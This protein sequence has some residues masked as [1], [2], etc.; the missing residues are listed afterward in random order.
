V[1]KYGAYMCNVK[2][3]T[4]IAILSFS[5]LTANPYNDA[6]SVNTVSLSQTE[7]EFTLPEFEI[8]EYVAQNMTFAKIEMEGAFA[9]AEAGLP[10]LPHFSATI[11]VPIGS[12]PVF[13]EVTFSTPRYQETLPIIPVQNY[14][15]LPINEQESP[16]L[17]LESMHEAP[18]FPQGKGDYFDYNTSFYQ[19]KDI[20]I[21]YPQTFYF[22]T[23]VQTLRDYQFIIIK[24]Y[25]IKYTPANNSIEIIDSF[26]FTINHHTDITPITY[27]A[28]PTISK[29]FEKIYEHTFQ[30]YHQVR[31]PNPAYQEQSIL[32]IYGG[33]S[34]V[35]TP[36]FWG[37][38][39]NMVNLKKQKGFEV[40]VASTQTIGATT[41]EIKSYIQNLY[42]SSPNPPEWIILLGITGAYLLP[43]YSV[44]FIGYPG[45]SDYPYTHLAGNDYIGDA[46]IGRIPPTDENQLNNFWQKI[47][48]YEL[49]TPPT[50]PSLYK[51]ALL[52]GHSQNSGI[53]T[54]IVNRYIKSLIEDYDPTANIQEMYYNNSQSTN[55]HNN[56]NAGHNIFNFR[57]YSGMDYFSVNSITNTN[58]LTNVLTL[59]CQT[60]AYLNGT[61]VQLV[62]RSYNGSPAGAISAIGIHT[63]HTETEYNNV[64]DGGIFYAMYVMDVAT[65][66][67]ALLYGKIFT[68]IVYPDNGQTNA[69]IHWTNLMGDPS[70]YYFKTTPSIFATTLPTTITAGTQSFRFVITD[71]AGNSV[72]DAWVTISKADGS[73]V[74]KA[75]SDSDGV[76]I[77]P[78]DHQQ[79]GSLM[80]A[81]SKPGFHVKR[82]SATITGNA[83]ITVIDKVINDPAPGGNDSQTINPGEAIYLGIKV[84]NFTSSDATDLTATISTESE[85][86]TLTGDTMVTLGS[87]AA[88]TEAL[89]TDAFSFEVSPLVPDKDLLPFAFVITDGELSWTSY[90]LLEVQGID[91]K[92][93]DINPEYLIIGDGTDITFT[94]KNIGSIPSGTLQAELISQS[95]YLTTSEETVTI[96]NINVGEITTQSTP[97]SVLTSTLCI[98]GMKLKADLH[99]FNDIG[100]ET[101]IPVELPVGN[102][103]VGDP[104]GPD[105]YGYVIYHSSDTNIIE[106]P[107]YNWINI[108]NI[109]TNT[110]MSDISASQEEDSREIMLP[111]LAGFYGQQHDRITIC[112]NGWLVFGTTMQKDFRN[113]PLPGPVAPRPLISPYWT[114]LVVGGT[115][116]GGVYTY[117]SQAEHA[118]IVQFDKVKWVTGY[119]G[120]SGFTTSSDSVTF[121]VLIYD[122]M[123]N[124]TAL[125][126]SKI[127]IQYQRFH[128]G[129]A[130]N[131]DNPFQY[132]T[133][134]IQNQTAST[135]IEY[136]YNN[137]YS[138]GSNTLTSGSALLITS[139]NIIPPD[140][141]YL[142]LY[143]VINP[144][145]GANTVDMGTTSELF[146]SV[147]N[148]TPYT[149]SNIIFTL[150]TTSN[151]AELIVAEHVVS[152]IEGNTTYTLPEPFSI[153]VSSNSTDQTIVPMLLT[154]S[155]RPQAWQMN[156]YVLINAPRF[157][158]TGL[159]MRNSA[160]V[161]V[162]HFLPG[163]DGSIEIDIQNTG[164]L[165]TN[166]G[167]FYITTQ[168]NLLSIT[169][170]EMQIPPLQIDEIITFT[171]N[172]H[173]SNIAPSV[174]VLSISYHI[175]ALEQ[176]QSGELYIPIGQV[177][178]GFETGNFSALPWNIETVR[179]WTVVNT[180]PSS[181]AYCA[182]SGII[183]NNQST[184]LQ[185][186]WPTS[187][188]GTITFD[189][190]VSSEE[191]NDFLNFYINDVLMGQWSGYLNTWQTASYPV[192]AN[193][194]NVFRWQYEKDTN[195][196][197][198]MDR[199]WIDNIVFP[200]SSAN[201]EFD[202]SLTPIN[203]SLKANYPNPFNPETVISF[204]VSREDRVSLD[205]YNLRGQKVRSLVNSVYG[206]GEHYV[207]WNGRDDIG[208]P[209]SSGVY[210][211]RMLSGEYVAVKK[212]LLLK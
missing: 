32:L 81:I 185:I 50:E 36:T 124:A 59:T 43:G 197:G 25:P 2:I 156:F 167:V 8:K 127:K 77:L 190:R 53:S 52:V 161:L 187:T 3:A 126:D 80:F 88:G 112:S 177:I 96:T 200:P 142:G 4:I 65:M 67:E 91:L 132:I 168:N 98:S 44:T 165:P 84:K 194:S 105:D 1:W 119:S 106:R 172:I 135:G 78:H 5:L 100:F 114:D 68:N 92:V 131:I 147:R 47:Q 48:K 49:N 201:S 153:A 55:L 93:T 62:N 179:P 174:T 134:G 7:I 13:E 72:P 163:D 157:E 86:V 145:T 123:Y 12:V 66:G 171:S 162:N 6:I 11:A 199:A 75:I 122:P 83:N 87:I 45:S 155:T 23:E 76:A 181:G 175:D 109:G 196:S 101:Y 56:F 149:A 103:V 205:I 37:Y 211:Y 133:V 148:E 188:A 99:L 191:D 9:G 144:E 204:S 169:D 117:H 73:Y 128:P 34:S 19:S 125:G 111:F 64:I 46:F 58:I 38:L 61:T 97:F 102:K 209:V 90:L 136:T 110:G 30:N 18:P 178:E 118:F 137:V 104:T 26:H 143:G 15:R 210:F 150:T 60:G 107:T 198:G 10:D 151:D 33:E 108:A 173:I 202:H 208:R 206:V 159:Q 40:T 35:H 152:S 113:L 192:P 115:F 138:L 95:Q 79:T 63:Y 121:Q 140:S 154:A 212:M 180:N 42:D 28:R 203:T 57:G 195:T 158:I 71:E 54:Y 16:M 27:T 22:K 129:I 189:Y 141:P 116:G 14:E 193:A 170:T 24:I 94:I 164:H 74:S 182:Q 120:S 146:I 130:G 85:Y 70:L 82:G 29:P 69:T 160:S 184:N 39:N 41:S 166:S 31:S 186:A 89:Y 183:S 139:V 20:K 176:S 17:P 21:T 207:V 51:K